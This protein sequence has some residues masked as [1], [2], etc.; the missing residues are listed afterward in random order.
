MDN[1]TTT[2]IAEYS[3]TAAALADLALRMANVVYDVSTPKGLAAAKADRAEVRNLRVALEKKRVEI[4]GPALKRCQEI[5]TEAKRITAELLKYETPPDD[6]I[7]AEERRI[8]A[9]RLAAVKREE[10][11]VKDISARIQSIRDAVSTAARLRTSAEIVRI[12]ADIEGRY[13]DAE[14]YAEFKETATL[15]KRE[16]VAELERIRDE[17]MARENEAEQLRKDREEFE[18]KRAEQEAKDKAARDAENERLRGE[19]EKFEA[20]QAEVR[21]KERER[22]AAIDAENERVAAEQRAE[23]ERIAG[24]RRELEARQQAE[25]DAQA[26]RDRKAEAQRVADEQEAERQHIANYRPS[27]DEIVAI[28]AANYKRTPDVVRTW[29]VEAK[30]PKQ[31][32]AA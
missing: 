23:Q 24:E 28:V 25:R 4:K 3:P 31:R 15:A 14:L 1:T 32:A 11:R 29:I 10:D 21:K 7:K 2:A 12:L 27:F 5:D 19:R 8:E 26:E 16:S 13:I 9:E 6:A 17:M 30:Q 22:Q 20:E 18:R